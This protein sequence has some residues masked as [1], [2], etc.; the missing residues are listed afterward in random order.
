[1]RRVKFVEPA[2]ASWTKWRK[3]CNKETKM[4]VDNWQPEKEFKIKSGLYKR[5]KSEVYFDKKGPFKGKCA[6]CETELRYHDD[7]DHYRPKKGVDD[8]NDDTIRININGK[9]IDHPGYYWLAYSWN[10]LFPTCKDCNAPSTVH[11]VPIGKRNRFPI[12]GK[13]AK[14][15]GEEKM[16]GPLLLNP[17]K[18]FP[19]KHFRWD[20]KHKMII[21]KPTSKKAKMTL[22]ILGFHQREQLR[23]D[24]IKAYKLVTT[25]Y[26]RLV[27]KLSEN[28]PNFDHL[29]NDFKNGIKS[30]KV[31]HSFVALQVLKKIK[32]LI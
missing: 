5:L 30:G 19:E 32:E 14:K 8:E 28:D 25:D 2:T 6:Y 18:D 4:L 1:M 7:L 23:L 24:W 27:Q 13:Y 21:A 15:P 31:L 22:K 16:E 29:L 9:N 10:N 20:E 11:K 17:L 3:D 12:A 26:A